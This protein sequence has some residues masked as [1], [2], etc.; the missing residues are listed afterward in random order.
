LEDVSEKKIVNGKLYYDLVKSK[1]KGRKVIHERMMYIGK[2]SGVDA[3]GR[4]QLVL[5]MNQLVV[6]QYSVGGVFPEIEAL[7]IGFVGKLKSRQKGHSEAG[8]SVEVNGGILDREE[9]ALIDLRSFR[10][11][12]AREGGGA[13]MVHQVIKQL[14]LVSFLQAQDNLDAQQIEY[15]LLNLQGRMLNPV[16]ERATALWAEEKSSSKSLLGQVHQVYEE[17]LH[18]AS[19]AWWDIHEEVEDYLYGRL[20]SLLDFGQSRFLY[21]LTNTYFE[22][23]MLGSSLARYG[24]SK[25]RRSDAPLV[26]VGLLS[27]ELGFIRRSHFH[28]GNVNEPGTL[29]Q[30]YEFLEDTPGIV[31]DAGIGTAANIEELARRGIPYMCV[32]REGFREYEVN[33]EQGQ[34]FTHHASN[35]QQ[36][37]VWLQYRVHTFEVEG[38]PYMDYLIFVKSQA[39]QAK[40]DGIVQKQKTRFQA[41]LQA[42]RSS[43]DKPRGHKTIPQVHQ[44]LGRLKAKNTRVAKAFDIQT[45]DDGK[46]ITGL[47]WDYNPE[48]EQRNGS[49]IIR[50]SEPVE[51]IHQAWKDYCALTKI[52]AVNRCCK[53]DLNLR[54][55]YHQ[56]DRTIQAHLFLTLIA[57]TIVHFIRHQLAQAGIHWSWKE[58]VRIM[59]TQKVI[60]SEFTNKHKEWFLLSNWS[61]PE[62]KAKQIYDALQIDYQPYAGF[63]FKVAKDDP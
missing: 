47:T 56:K 23:R 6:G 40:E 25:E 2:L 13:W 26:S 29:E 24:R 15:M 30:V 16:S 55:V 20:D 42:I 62:A 4:K 5:R 22:G 21:D 39:K 11:V 43:L 31:T 51:D 50:R 35:G 60:A 53:T 18:Q 61:Y 3:S 1:R 59:N 45:T 8:E 48:G 32:V 49:Y 27:N 58:I 41:G 63:F 57:C 34:Y 12:S 19:W 37:G 52:E 9:E 28:A 44:R 36:Y 46:N 54:P 17:G 38:K 33:F 14:G 7:A 10:P